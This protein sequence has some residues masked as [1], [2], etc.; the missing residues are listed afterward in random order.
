VEE[1]SALIAELEC[2]AP[3]ALTLPTLGYR[4]QVIALR[5]GE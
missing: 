4:R 1:K 5:G 3:Q 2:K